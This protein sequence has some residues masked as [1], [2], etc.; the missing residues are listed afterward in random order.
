MQCLVLPPAISGARAP[1]GMTD[2][3]RRRDV[4]GSAQT[5]LPRG[6]GHASQGGCPHLEEALPARA[7]C[8]KSLH[9]PSPNIPSHGGGC[10]H[11]LRHPGRDVRQIISN[12]YGQSI[13]LLRKLI[14]YNL[15]SATAMGYGQNLLN[16]SRSSFD[17]V[18]SLISD[19]VSDSS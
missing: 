16:I 10:P 13:E 8:G 3:F 14:P 2:A 7:A 11:L 1:A 18:S 12:P 6:P 9:Q 15:F 19:D 4:R 5:Q 17:L